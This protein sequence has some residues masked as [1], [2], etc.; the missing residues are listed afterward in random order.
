LDYDLFVTFKELPQTSFAIE[1]FILHPA[2][3]DG[4][5]QPKLCVGQEEIFFV[6]W[7]SFT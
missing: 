2:L 5:D 1:V 6:L 4:R 3:F 7:R